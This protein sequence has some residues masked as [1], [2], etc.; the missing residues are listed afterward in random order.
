MDAQQ[1]FYGRVVYAGLSRMTEDRSTIQRGFQFW[2]NKLASRAFEVKEVVAYIDRYLGI[3]TAEKKALFI[4][5]QSA[6]NKL[7]DQLAPVPA[8]ILGSDDIADEAAQPKVN[9]TAHNAVTTAMLQNMVQQT[10][11][12]DKAAFSELSA[13]IADEGFSQLPAEINSALND[14]AG[15]NLSAL[16][17]PKM[18]SVEDCQELFHAYYLLSTELIGPVDTDTFVD[19]AVKDSRNLDQA[20]D[21]NPNQLL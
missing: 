2:H 18:I 9:L 11:R 14:W 19:S 8:F 3:N 4:A 13:I 12:L 5:M 21:F 17:L 15:N 6:S 7:P 20:G 16:V 1:E 10:K